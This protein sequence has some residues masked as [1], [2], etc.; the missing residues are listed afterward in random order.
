MKKVKEM[1]TQFNLKNGKNRALI[2]YITDA[3]P[4]EIDQVI[5]DVFESLNIETKRFVE[6]VAEDEASC[7]VMKY[8][9]GEPKTAL[10]IALKWNATSRRLRVGGSFSEVCVG[11]FF[12]NEPEPPEPEIVFVPADE[13]GNPIGEPEYEEPEPAP[14]ITELVCDALRETFGGVYGASA[15]VI[16]DNVTSYILEIE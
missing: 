8:R 15:F 5:N 16:Q 12:Y 10:N 9:F 1:Q 13:L 4:S 6:V 14:S 2:C 11:A 3:E 7:N